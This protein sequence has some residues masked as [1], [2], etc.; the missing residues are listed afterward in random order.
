MSLGRDP[1]GFPFG[2]EG[3]QGFSDDGVALLKFLGIVKLY[4]MAS[5][6]GGKGELRGE[7]FSGFRGISRN[8]KQ[9]AGGLVVKVLDKIVYSCHSFFFIAFKATR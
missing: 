9:G 2:T 8:S 4:G 3:R 6:V 5:V 1:R 7:V